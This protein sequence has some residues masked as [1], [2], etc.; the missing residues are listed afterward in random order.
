MDGGLFNGQRSSDRRAA[1]PNRGEAASHRTVEESQPP[2]EH[3]RQ[4]TP[5]HHEPA[6][7]KSGKGLV[8]AVVI[9]AVVAILGIAAWLV[10]PRLTAAGG[11]GIDNGK[12]Q[13]VFFTNGQV[14]FGKLSVVNDNYLKLTDIFYLQTKSS[15]SDS[16]DS[17]QKTSTESQSD[18]QL[19]KLGSEIHGPEDEMIIS[20]DQVL[21]YE[22]LKNDGKVGQSIKQYKDQQ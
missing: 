11:T 22:N 6:K 20:R 9:G 14:Y 19:I 10:V 3:H 21:F 15:E 7:K 13:A 5:S 1:A 17:L 8:L 18:V 4:S 16:S 12:Y 2:V